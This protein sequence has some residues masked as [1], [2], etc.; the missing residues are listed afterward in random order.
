M[1]YR[2]EDGIQ[3]FVLPRGARCTYTRKHPDNM[4]VCPK[5]NG[6]VCI[7]D[8]CGYYYEYANYEYANRVRKTDD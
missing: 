6:D 5:N 8:E 2:T 1:E 3:F 4:D 7:P